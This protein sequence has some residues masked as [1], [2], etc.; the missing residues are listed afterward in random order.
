[1]LV[2]RNITP[3][4]EPGG[5]GLLPGETMMRKALIVGIDSYKHVRPLHG[6]TN[7]AHA[8]KNVLERNADGTVNFDVKLLVAST[9]NGAVARKELRDA[10]RDLFVGTHDVALFYFAGHGHIEEAGGYLFVS[11]SETGDD[12][13]PLSEVLTF[14]N[15]SR[16]QSKIIILDSCHSGIAG[17][18]PEINRAYLSDGLTVLTASGVEQYATE[19]DGSGL[20]TTLLVDALGGAAADLMGR[21]TP[22]A[23]YAHIDQSLGAWEQRPVF[24]TNVNRFVSLRQVPPPVE[25]AELRRIAEL[26]PEAGFHFRLDPSFEPEGPGPDHMNTQIFRLLQKYNRVNLLLP[27]GA[28]HLYHAAMESASC[29]LT[30]LGEHYRRLAA[31]GRL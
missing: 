19:R 26:F 14:A 31:R 13:I 17:S 24:K 22:G 5:A 30:V 25:L 8:V 1:M 21:V 3:E 27:V 4:R 10:I 23:V 2:G 29:R 11:D 20:F 16:A 6:C 28:P 18:L 9:P 7:D 12:G 15:G